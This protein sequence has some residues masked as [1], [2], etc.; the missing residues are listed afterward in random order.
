M[1]GCIAICAAFS[2]YFEFAMTTALL[3]ALM[4]AVAAPMGDLFESYVKRACDVKDSGNIL[5]GHGGMMD[6]FDSLLFVMPLLLGVLTFL[7]WF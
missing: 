1:V 6:R 2:W 3:L 5:P 7:R 4:V